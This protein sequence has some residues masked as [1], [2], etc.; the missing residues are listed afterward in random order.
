MYYNKAIVAG[1]LTRDPELRSLPSGAKVCNLGVATNRVYKD[2]EGR[3]Q[4]STEFHNIVIFGQQ[5]ENSAQYLRKGQQVLVEGRLQTRSWDDQSSGQKK[6]RTEI[7][8]DLVQFGSRGGG[9]QGAG[10]NDNYTQ[11]DQSRNDG[12]SASN[13][14]EQKTGSSPTD[15]A[16]AGGSSSGGDEIDYPEEEINPE[17]IPF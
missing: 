14:N 16:S 7:V 8:A 12:S 11:Q 1:N 9:Q 2:R 5:A 15:T 17:D 4:E 13:N 10:A 6:Y 3:R